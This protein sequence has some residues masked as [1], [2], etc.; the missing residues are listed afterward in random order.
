MYFSDGPNRNLS[1]WALSASLMT[2]FPAVPRTEPPPIIDAENGSRTLS[3]LFSGLSERRTPSKL[4]RVAAWTL[5]T[6]MG[7]SDPWKFTSGG[8]GKSAFPFMATGGGPLC[9]A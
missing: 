7:G 6:I 2:G 5:E 8:N 1:N 9:K 4:G 3:F